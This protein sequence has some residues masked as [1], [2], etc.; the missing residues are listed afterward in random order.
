MNTAQILYEQYK[1]LPKKVKNELKALINSENEDVLD[2]ISLPAI[3]KGLKEI[4]KLK[5]GNAATTNAREFLADLKK[6][7][8]Q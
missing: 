4:K 8:A 2:D 5:A 7:L 6:E 3:R 1:I